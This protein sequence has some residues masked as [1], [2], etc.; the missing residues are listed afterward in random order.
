MDVLGPNGKAERWKMKKEKPWSVTD[1]KGRIKKEDGF[2]R[3]FDTI[4]EAQNWIDENHPKEHC[5]MKPQKWGVVVL[6]D[7][8]M[9]KTKEKA[10][11][12]TILT[13]YEAEVIKMRENLRESLKIFKENWNKS[14][15]LIA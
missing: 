2:V 13:P 12:F 3:G 8:E 1:E 4:D 9:K 10:E 6:K 11:S 7:V 15:Y 5:N 14:E